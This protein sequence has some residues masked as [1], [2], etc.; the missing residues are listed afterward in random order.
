MT[1]LHPDTLGLNN[2]KFKLVDTVVIKYKH[3]L[4]ALFYIFS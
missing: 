2:K 4:F 3:I 1:F